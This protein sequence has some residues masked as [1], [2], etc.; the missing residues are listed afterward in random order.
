MNI[1]NV[2]WEV[3][4]IKTTCGTLYVSIRF[5]INLKAFEK[6]NYRKLS[7]GLDAHIFPAEESMP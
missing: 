7:D 3:Q 6:G 5:F 4:G 2:E 1:S